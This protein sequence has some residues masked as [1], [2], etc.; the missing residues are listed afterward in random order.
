MNKSKPHTK[1][2][3]D[4]RRTLDAIERTVMGFD[5]LTIWTD[6]PAPDIPVDA[7]QQHC[8]KLEV[9]DDYS[10]AFHPVWQTEIKIFQPSRQALIELQRALGPRRRTTVRY[11]EVALDWLANHRSAA[12]VIYDFVLERLHVPYMRQPV[13][14][15]E[16]TAYFARRSSV[17]GSKNGTIVAMYADRVSDLWPA[18]QLPLPCC[19]LEYRLQGAET[20]AQYGLLSLPD[21]IGFDHQ[22]FWR[23]HLRLFRLPKKLDLGY[24][25]APENTD[26]SKEALR[27][28]A[29]RILDHYRH[30]DAIV[31]QNLWRENPVIDDLITR[32]DNSPFINDVTL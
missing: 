23:E 20:L 8:R 1:R 30:G 3:V 28:R 13:V 19:H 31:L 22:A 5:R 10:L 15:E 18:H 11:A 26:V 21:C 27:K 17:D 24:R 25:L 14:F 32:I 29:N 6:H 4:I 16:G 2:P 12:Q 7:I 9:K